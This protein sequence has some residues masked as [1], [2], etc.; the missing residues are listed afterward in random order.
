VVAVAP[1]LVLE[2]PMELAAP[3]VVVMVALIQ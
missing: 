2:L 3:V 1:V